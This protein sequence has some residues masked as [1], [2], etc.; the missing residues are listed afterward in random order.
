MF[1]IWLHIV[2]K[3]ARCFRNANQTS[4]RIVVLLTRVNS[5]FKWL[6]LLFKTPRGPFTVIDRPF[7]EKVTKKSF[8][9]HSTLKYQNSYHQPLKSKANI[10]VIIL[11]AIF[12]QKRKYPFPYS[13]YDCLVYFTGGKL[14]FCSRTLK[15]L[16]SKFQ[17]NL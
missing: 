4:T 1:W 14:F 5:R 16:Y 2:L 15:Y 12:H 3:Q 11:R 6:K 13:I 8:K 10:Y 17:Q 9:Y 7:R